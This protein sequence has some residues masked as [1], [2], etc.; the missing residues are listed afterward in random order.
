MQIWTLKDDKAYLFAN[1]ADPKIYSDHLQTI[2][3]M[4]RSLK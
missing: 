2:Q 3:N 1:K 4:I